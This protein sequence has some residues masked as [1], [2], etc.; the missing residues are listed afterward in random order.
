MATQIKQINDWLEEKAIA[1][2][3]CPLTGEGRYPTPIEYNQ[4]WAQYIRGLKDIHLKSNFS[5]GGFDITDSPLSDYLKSHSNEYNI[6]HITGSS[7][8]Y[9]KTSPYEEKLDIINKFTDANSPSEMFCE[10]DI[11]GTY[12]D[13]KDFITGTPSEL[14]KHFSNYKSKPSKDEDYMDNE[15]YLLCLVDITYF[16]KILAG[17]TPTGFVF[18]LQMTDR[19]IEGVETTHNL[20]LKSQP[21]HVLPN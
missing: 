4:H 12:S 14:V 10:H 3:N 13:S 18:F 1:M 5:I 11:K 9:K 20:E 15:K 8:Y 2:E 19:K 21:I 17:P 7:T 16:E 6:T